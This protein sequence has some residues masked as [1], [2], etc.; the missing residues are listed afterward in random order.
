MEGNRILACPIC[1]TFMGSLKCQK[2]GK[3]LTSEEFV[4]GEMLKKICPGTG[5]DAGG[6]KIW[7]DAVVMIPAGGLTCKMAMG[8]LS[9]E[10]EE[11]RL[12][13]PFTATFLPVVDKRLALIH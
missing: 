2:H 8:R 3:L 5:E 12:D 13:D 7:Q 1:K 10:E 9:E 11:R 6:P 4:F